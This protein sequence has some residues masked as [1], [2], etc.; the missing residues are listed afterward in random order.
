MLK[1]VVYQQPLGHQNRQLNQNQELTTKLSQS[2]LCVTEMVGFSVQVV[3]AGQGG[4]KRQAMDWRVDTMLHGCERASSS[5]ARQGRDRD[6][7]LQPSASAAA[8]EVSTGESC[9]STLP[10][11]TLAL[12]SKVQLKLTQFGCR[13]VEEELSSGCDQIVKACRAEVGAGDGVCPPP[14]LRLCSYPTLLCSA[15]LYSTPASDPAQAYGN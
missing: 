3:V 14:M 5:R 6:Q 8:H 1:D 13:N 11:N 15:L 9:D 2:N 10:S 7:S 4:C 12:L